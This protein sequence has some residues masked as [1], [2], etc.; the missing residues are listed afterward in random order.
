MYFVSDMYLP[1]T[2][3]AQ[4]LAGQGYT[5][6]EQLYVSAEDDLVKGDGSR[7]INLKQQWGDQRVLHIGDNFVSDYQAPTDQGFDAIHYQTP[8]DFYTQDPIVGT[9][10]PHLKAAHSVGLDFVL[11]VYRCWKY[12]PEAKS[13]SLWADIGFLFG[14]PLLYLFGHYIQQRTLSTPEAPLCF[15]ARD[16]LIIK[17][18]YDALF[19]LPAQR[20]EYVLASRRAM[21]FPLFALDSAQDATHPLLN[22][23]SVVH[24]QATATEIIERLGYTDLT[25]LQQDLTALQGDSHLTNQAQV[26]TVLAQHYS[27]LRTKAQ[28]ELQGLEHYLDTLQLLDSDQAATAPVLIDVGWLGTIQ[29]SLNALMAQIRPKVHFNGLYLG[30]LPTAKTPEDKHGVLFDTQHQ[31]HYQALSSFIEF[32]ELLTAAPT[33][34]VLRFDTSSEQVV[35]NTDMNIEE[36]NRIRVAKELHQGIMGY[37]TQMQRL[38]PAKRPNLSVDDVVTLLSVLPQHA[39]PQVIATLSQIKHAPL[40][41]NAY[42][43]SIFDF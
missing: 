1:K 28:L 19:K 8:H 39:S 35:W 29:D 18:V 26:Q 30:V 24:E 33:P 3:I 37:V 20:T 15:L 22:M 5:D 36:K 7:F 21:T 10:Y 38:E 13:S 9:L 14:G 43:H 32:I 27:A 17:Q 11:G 6:Y 23:Y 12:S 42:T 2:H 31:Q 4:L 40:P 25:A 34:G 16:G 41:S